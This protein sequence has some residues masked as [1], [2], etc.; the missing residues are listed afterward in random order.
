ME[1]RSLKELVKQY[2]NAG[3]VLAHD[4]IDGLIVYCKDG[5]E[6]SNDVSDWLLV[7]DQREVDFDCEIPTIKIDKL[8]KWKREV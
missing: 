4:I 8:R 1:K 6:K 5:N 2:E 7:C 3:Y